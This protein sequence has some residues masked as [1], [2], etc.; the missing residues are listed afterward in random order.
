MTY[1][2]LVI[3]VVHITSARV[4][5]FALFFPNFRG[6][7][8]QN[9]NQVLKFNSLNDE[10]YSKQVFRISLPPIAVSTVCTCSLNYV[11][12]QS[13]LQLLYTSCRW[14]LVLEEE[15]KGSQWTYYDC[16]SWYTPLCVLQSH[17]CLLH[18]KGVSSCT[19]WN[20]FGH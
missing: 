13:I 12:S 10:F 7:F 5:Y 9:Y 17:L 11:R 20:T 15:C 6:R 3:A 4:T 8:R 18:M 16:V 14:L 2:F 19:R 1:N